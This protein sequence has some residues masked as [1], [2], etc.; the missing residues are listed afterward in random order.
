MVVC[1][2]VLGEISFWIG[3]LRK[4]HP[5]QWAW[6]SYHPLRNRIEQNSW[7]KGECDLFTWAGT[8]ICSCTQALILL[9]PGPWTQIEF[10]S[11]IPCSQSCVLELNSTT[12][13]PGSQLVD[14]RSWDLKNQS[15][16]SIPVTNLLLS[17]SLY[18]IFE[19]SFG[20]PWPNINVIQ[21]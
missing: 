7:R 13:F 18:I 4:D 19:L 2:S 1:E 3:K 10:A 15:Q 20:E 21:W 8:S 16:E 17:I 14:E 11:S 12:G 6:A 9:V 5:L